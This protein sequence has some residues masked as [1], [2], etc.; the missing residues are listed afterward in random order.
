MK[1]FVLFG[2]T[3][4]AEIAGC[5]A[6]YAVLR[7]GWRPAWIVAALASLLIFAWLLTLHPTGGAGRIYAAYGGV[8]IAASLLWLWAIEKITPDRW[9]LMGALFCLTGTGIIILVPRN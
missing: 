2:F 5:Y 8:Y 7:L 1:T 4:L 3:A 9:D 6:I